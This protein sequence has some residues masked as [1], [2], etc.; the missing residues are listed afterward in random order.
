MPKQQQK[1]PPQIQ[2]GIIFAKLILIV[3][4]GKLEKKKKKEIWRQIPKPK[5]ISHTKIRE[6]K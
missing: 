5:K 6:R 4:D 2:K 1:K 3:R